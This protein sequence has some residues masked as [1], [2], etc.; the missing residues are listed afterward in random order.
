MAR[1]IDFSNDELG[2]ALHN[3]EGHMDGLEQP[4]LRAFRIMRDMIMRVAEQTREIE[5]D[6]GGR[7]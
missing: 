3:I 2:A 5:V 7:R 4:E 6:L 1:L